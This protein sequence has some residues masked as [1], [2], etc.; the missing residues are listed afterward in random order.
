LTGLL[1]DHTNS[2]G[3]LIHVGGAYSFIDPAN[4]LVRYRNQPELF[5]GETGGA[6]LVPLGVP[7]NLPAFVDTGLIA[8]EY[9]NLFAVELAA[10]VGPFH[11]QSEAIFANVRQSAGGDLLFPGAYVQFGYVLTGEHR[12]YNRKNAVFGRV[13]PHCSAGAGGGIGA[14]ELT[15]RWSS[16]DLDDGTIQGGQLEDFTAGLNWYI[17]P[18]AKFQFNYVHA[19]LDS[20]VNGESDANLFAARAQIDF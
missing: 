1:V 13:N 5:V 6:G 11:A 20:P 2:E 19:G 7:S 14:W 15:A 17:N 10:S 18:H 3:W 4:D 9:V 16:I 8:T 12:P